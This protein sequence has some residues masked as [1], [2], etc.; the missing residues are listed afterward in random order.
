[1]A[2]GCGRKPDIIWSEEVT[3][4]SPEPSD[5]EASCVAGPAT[6]RVP[7]MDSLKCK[8]STDE[9]RVPPN[10]TFANK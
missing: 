1:M 8:Y 3:N 4:L 7:R 6:T 2:N 5:A 10:E 9:V